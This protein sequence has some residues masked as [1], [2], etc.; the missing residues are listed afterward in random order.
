MTR[1]VRLM[2]SRMLTARTDKASSTPKAAAIP[3]VIAMAAIGAPSP[4]FL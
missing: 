4:E 3:P 1:L 2:A